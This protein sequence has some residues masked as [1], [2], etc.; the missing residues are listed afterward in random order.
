MSI[1]ILRCYVPAQHRLQ[2]LAVGVF[3]LILIGGVA[4]EQAP[5]GQPKGDG[6]LRSELSLGGRTATL[7]CAPDLKVNDAAHKGLLSATSGS[8][9]AR[10][11]VG[12]LDTTGSLRIGTI[13]L[14]GPP[15]QVQT[16]A[17]PQPPGQESAAVQYDLWL[18]GANNG[19]QLQVTGADKGVA[20]QIPLSRQAAAPAS[21]NLVAALIPEDSTVGRLVLRWGDYQATA[22]VQFSD[23]SRRRTEENRGVNVTTNRRHDDDTSV[24]SRARLLAQRNETALML[25]KG[26]RISV[27]FQRTFA[28]ADR[29]D[30]NPNTSRGLGV[31]GPDFARLMQTPDGAIVMLTESSVPRLRTEVPLRFGKALIDTGNQ[32]AGFPGSYGVWLKRVGSG[33]RLVFNNEPDA[34]GSQHDPK[35]DAAEIELSHSEGHAATRPFAVAIVPRAADRGR[36]VIVWG[37]HEW[38]ADFVAS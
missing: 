16:P 20:G 19:W 25:P 38:T 7:A 24:L 30:G 37:P 9:P 36:L 32:V 35:F 22:D 4:T 14:A 29:T 1:G 6:L 15:R 28:R 10:V 33:W 17:G 27:S 18:E 3:L 8:A 12:Q 11:R 34:W 31:D 21:P 13:N 5:P 23:P 2:T 26:P